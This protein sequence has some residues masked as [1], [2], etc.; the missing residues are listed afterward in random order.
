[1][2]AFIYIAA[3]ILGLLARTIL[4]QIFGI[5][6]DMNGEDFLMGTAAIG[7]VYGISSL[8]DRHR[9]KEHRDGR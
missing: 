4:T 7:M 9:K 8:A 1:M 2:K 6:F 5:P 3:F